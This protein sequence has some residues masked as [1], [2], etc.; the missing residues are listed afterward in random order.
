METDRRR[1]FKL[2]GAAG[3]GIIA[4]GGTSAGGEVV[5]PASSQED[6]TET[7][8]TTE[9][10]LDNQLLE[11]TPGVSRRLHQAKKTS[12]EPCRPLRSLVRGQ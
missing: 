12:V 11:V 10:F 7:A 4:V 3:A 9:L 5:P 6:A 8:F 1:F 2:A